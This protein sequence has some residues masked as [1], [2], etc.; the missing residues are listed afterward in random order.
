MKSGETMKIDKSKA[1]NIL[2]E[3]AA[4]AESSP[5]N[6]RWHSKITRLSR[7]CEAGGVRTHIAFLGTAILAKAVNS[8]VDLYA[9][10][11]T[12]NQDNPNSF[13][14]RSLCHSVL[15]PL[16]AELGFNIGVT[17][18]EPLN[19][20]PYFRMTRLDDGTPVSANS[21]D[22][23]RYM[24][25]IIKQ[26]SLLESEED[27]REA[28]RAFISVRRNY[29]P[30][31]NLDFEGNLISNAKLLE[32]IEYFVKNDSENGKRAQ[33]VVAGFMDV[34]AGESRVESGRI[35]DPS[36][37][38]PGDVCVQSREDDGVWEKAFEVRD[39]PVALSDIYIFGNKCLSMGVLE[40]A[41]VMLSERQ[42]PVDFEALSHWEDRTGI[43]VTLFLGWNAFIN[44]VLFWADLPRVESVLKAVKFIHKRLIS[45]EASQEALTLWEDLV[46]SD[47]RTES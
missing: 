13:S 45:I 8:G 15:V 21:A 46:N 6:S 11:P 22:S 1:E 19:N 27:A 4:L 44:Q 35:N 36:R 33:A 42:E 20:Q 16:A 37:H 31:Y 39:K 41:I 14:A 32:I 7:F 25:G 30:S 17:G 9:V 43:G 10:K 38:Y 47:Y 26:L 28:L 2:R 29:T 24:L 5:T 23:F 18:R 34:F 40:P 12:H 3:E